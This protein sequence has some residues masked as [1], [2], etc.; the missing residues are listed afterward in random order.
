M[1]HS[2]RGGE[3]NSGSKGTGCFAYIARC[4]QCLSSWLE[5]IYLSSPCRLPSVVLLFDC[6]DLQLYSVNA[7]ISVFFLMS[8]LVCVRAFTLCTVLFLLSVL[9]FFFQIKKEQTQKYLKNPTEKGWCTF[10]SNCNTIIWSKVKRVMF[11]SLR[12]SSEN[13]KQEIKHGVSHLKVN[14]LFSSSFRQRSKEIKG[15]VWQINFMAVW[16]HS[17]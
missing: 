4:V 8:G 10:P 16:I 5:D 13:I 3:N 6:T 9:C 14:I 2:N 17:A 7:L 15:L 12:V 1:N 11:N